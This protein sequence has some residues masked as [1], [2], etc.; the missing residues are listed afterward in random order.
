MLRWSPVSLKLVDPRDMRGRIHFESTGNVEKEFGNMICLFTALTV[1][2]I[3]IIYMNIHETANININNR[4]SATCH[5]IINIV[6]YF[7]SCIVYS[8]V[9]D[10]EWFIPDPALNFSSSGSGSGSG[11]RQK[12]RIHAD[13]DPT[14]IN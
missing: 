1:Y 5:I 9:V 7:Y 14:Y 3:W 6:V 13:P 10:P 12:F 11:F 2:Y 4:K 8:S